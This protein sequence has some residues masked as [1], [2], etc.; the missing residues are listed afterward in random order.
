[1]QTR[2]SGIALKAKERQ[3]LKRQKQPMCRWPVLLLWPVRDSQLDLSGSL[4]MVGWLWLAGWGWLFSL[5]CLSDAGRRP[6][7]CG[8][9]HHPWST[10]PHPD[11]NPQVGRR[12]RG[13][14]HN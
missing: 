10:D 13:A 1:M 3:Q 8:N 5:E 12:K 9:E 2:C 6:S 14:A 11:P 7:Q 4:L